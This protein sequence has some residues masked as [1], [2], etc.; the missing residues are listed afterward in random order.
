[1]NLSVRTDC[2]YLKLTGGNF[3]SDT[4]GDCKID[5]QDIADFSQNWLLS[6]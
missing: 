6:Y 1:M 3:V 4:N 5:F 2:E